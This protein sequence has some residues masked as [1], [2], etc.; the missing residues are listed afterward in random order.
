MSQHHTM[1]GP[2][3]D[4]IPQ[5]VFVFPVFRVRNRGPWLLVGSAVRPIFAISRR[6]RLRP[7]AWPARAQMTD[8]LTRAVPRR[9][10]ELLVDQTHQI[11]VR[12]SLG[13]WLAIQPGAADRD[14]PALR[15]RSDS[16]GW[17]GSIMA[18]LRSRLI[19][20]RLSAKKNRVP[21]QAG[22]FWRG[23]SRRQR[24]GSP[25][26]LRPCRKNTDTIPSI[27]CLRQV[28]IIV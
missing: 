20:R 13:R 2:G 5:K 3:D 19:D 9:G 10:H 11:E 26:Q 6:T 21:P 27:A 22:R 28:E 14:K 15:H 24:H 12:R 25:P 18:R 17:S 16:R 7:T 1:V 8:H 23:A 4:Q